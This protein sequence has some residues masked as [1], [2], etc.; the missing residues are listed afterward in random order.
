[1]VALPSAG[2]V[3]ISGVGLD[4]P[5]ATF[6]NSAIVLLPTMAL[7]DIDGNKEGEEDDI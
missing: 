5:R 1:M 7:M 2:A 3:G 4:V 6:A